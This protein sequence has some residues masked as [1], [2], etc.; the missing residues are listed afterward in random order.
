MLREK[1]FRLELLPARGA[2][3]CGA[4]VD[5]GAVDL[6]VVVEGLLRAEHREANL[7]LQAHARLVLDAEDAERHVLDKTRLRLVGLVTPG[8]DW[9]LPMQLER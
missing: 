9:F 6:H 1:H 8:A 2:G 3:D 7:A 5:P 4:Q